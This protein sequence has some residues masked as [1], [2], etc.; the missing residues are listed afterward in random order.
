MNQVEDVQVQEGTEEVFQIDPT[1]FST[2]KVEELKSWKDNGV[3]IE[4]FNENQ[5]TISVKWVYSFKNTDSGLV[6]KARLVARGFEEPEN[7]VTKESPT[8][9]K[10]SLRVIMAIITQKKWSLNTTD[11]KTAFFQGQTI[12]REIYLRPPREANTDKLWK[13]RNCVYGLS[14][15]SRK[16]YDQVKEFMLSVGCKMSVVDPAVFYY[17]QDGSLQGIIAVHVDDFFWAGLIIFKRNVISKL[18]SKFKVGKETASAFQYLG[19][20]VSQNENMYAW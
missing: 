9:S 1:D 16:W 10:D 11:I 4:V 8:C 6:P 18:R 3:Y 12:E 19:L 17:Y 14:D 15:A 2:A 20:G 7:D 5:G 13:L